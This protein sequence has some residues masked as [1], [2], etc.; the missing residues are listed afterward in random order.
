MPSTCRGG[1][2]KG[3]ARARP[4]SQQRAESKRR[5]QAGRAGPARATPGWARPAAAVAPASAPAGPADGGHVTP[6]GQSGGPGAAERG[7]SG[8]AAPGT[9]NMGR[10]QLSGWPAGSLGPDTRR[11]AQASPRAVSPGSSGQGGGGGG[12]SIRG[13][14]GDAAPSRWLGRLVRAWTLLRTVHSVRSSRPKQLGQVPTWLRGGDRARPRRCGGWGRG[15]RGAARR[16][17]GRG[18]TVRPGGT[19]GLGGWPLRARRGSGAE[20]R[21]P[22]GGVAAVVAPV[23]RLRGGD[24]PTTVAAPGLTKSKQLRASARGPGAGARPEG[25]RAAALRPR[26]A[27]GE[28]EALPAWA[29]HPWPIPESLEAARPER[30]PQSPPASSPASPVGLT[31]SG[32]EIRGCQRLLALQLV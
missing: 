28:E 31:L 30:A 20:A 8:W 26:D 9:T 24:G 17:G 10:K 25:L 27:C 15:G 2:R 1:Y 23:A 11:A 18:Q 3:V 5:T 14:K 12:R 19:V 21:A 13:A 4:P 6:A 29:P 16:V 22:R 7:S 32:G